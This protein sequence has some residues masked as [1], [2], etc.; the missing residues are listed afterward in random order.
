MKLNFF[1]QFFGCLGIPNHTRAFGEGLVN[2]LG[3]VR[4]CPIS[5]NV[6]ND[7]YGLTDTIKNAMGEPDPTAPSLVFWYPDKFPEILATVPNTS[8][9]IGYYIFE[10]TKIPQQYIEAINSSLDDICTASEWGCDVLKKNGVT[11]P[12]HCVPGGVNHEVFNSKNK[13]LDSKKFRFLHIGKAEAR[14]G[15]DIVIRA[16]NEAFKGDRKVKLSL[17][18][19]NPHLR[20][21]DADTLLND[22]KETYKLKYPIKN[23]E[24]RH[25]QK[26]LV[27]VYNSHHVAVFAS[28]SEGIG[29]PIVEAMACGLPCI[30]PYNSGITQYANDSNAILLK[31]LTETTIEDPIFLKGDYG[32][33]NVPSVEEMADRMLFAWTH[34]EDIEDLG[35]RAEQYMK[36]TYSWEDSCKIFQDILYNNN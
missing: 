1:G 27:S 11:I 20:D 12:I 31:N 35:L 14:K 29:L 23:I 22:L 10:Y 28:K 4:L 16:F 19:D 9:K 15:T 7:Q 17:Y 36:D 18:I 2:L 8:R 25:F 33:W 26:E 24:V 21:F 34:Q 13:S 5:P 3:D 32:T 6:S 30:I